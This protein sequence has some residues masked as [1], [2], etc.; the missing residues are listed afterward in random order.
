ML[1]RIQFENMYTI[2]EYYAKDK[3]WLILIYPIFVLIIIY[4]SIVYNIIVVHF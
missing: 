2:I 3:V 1:I 4:Y